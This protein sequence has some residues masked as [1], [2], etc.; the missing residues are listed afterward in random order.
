[1]TPGEGGRGGGGGVEGDDHEENARQR[2]RRLDSAQDF[3][4]RISR[5]NSNV[6][7]KPQDV[8]RT[9]SYIDES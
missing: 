6:L 2:E 7:I 1:M 3:W 5:S 9:F 8:R 4:V